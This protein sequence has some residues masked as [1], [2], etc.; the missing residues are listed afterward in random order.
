MKEK[1]TI[2]IF[3]LLVTTTLFYSFSGNADEIQ[4]G[5]INEQTQSV[6]QEQPSAPPEGKTIQESTATTEEKVVPT[7]PQPPEKK[8]IQETPTPPPS[9][10]P[11]SGEDKEILNRL[12]ELTKSEQLTIEGTAFIR[13][14][15]EIQNGVEEKEGEKEPRKNSFEVWRFY[16]GLRSTLS[17]WL[18]LRFTIDVGPEKEQTTSEEQGH[19]H[20][21]P[22]ES[23]VELYVKYAWLDFSI[24]KGLSLKAGL[25]DY[26]LND[27]IENFWGYRYVAKITGDEFKLWHSADLGFYLQYKIPKDIGDLRVGAVNGSGYK[28]ALDTDSAKEAW[29][30]MMFTPFKPFVKLLENFTIG[31]SSKITL[32]LE[33]RVD[34]DIV[35]TPF[36]GYANKWVSISYNVPIRFRHLIKDEKNIV[37]IA[38]GLNFKIMSPWNVGVFGQFSIWKEDKDIATEKTSYEWVGG[39]SYSPAKFFSVA[40][41]CFLAW[42]TM[43]DDP[44]TTDVVEKASEEKQLQILLSSLVK[45]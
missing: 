13:Y 22:G 33:D 12:K 45:F 44:S 42:Q 7:P 37:A 10:S 36:I 3:L 17:S 32:D 5:N 41:S 27:F 38:H 24:L 35:L 16:A 4:Q 40:L 18:K 43:K 11:S 2:K 29:I 6:I 31:G 34:R 23:S 26:P 21:V 30:Y 15:Y 20:K 9:P 19:T 1:S 28:N 8:V 39:I 14:W 25:I